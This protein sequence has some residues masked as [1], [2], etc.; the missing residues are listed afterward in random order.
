MSD[1]RTS[2]I[3]NMTGNMGNQSRKFGSDIHNMGQRGTKAI[4]MMNRGLHGL[5]RGL[6]ALGN[7]YTAFITGAGAAGAVRMV[8]NLEERLTKLGVSSSRSAEDVEKLK[9]EIF[10]IARQK[11]LRVDPDQL[12]SAVEEIVE[13]T[14]DLEY[15]KTNLKNFAAAI[16]A[17]SAE[18]SS[19]GGIASEFQKMGLINPKDVLE[20]LDLLIKQGKEGAFTLAE[21]AELAPRIFPAYTAR[22]RTGMAAV[23]EVGAALQIIMKGTGK[24]EM[25]VTAFESVLRVLADNSKLKKLQK[26]GINVFDNEKMKQGLEVIRPINEIVADIVRKT[27][28]RGTLLSEVLGDAEAARAFSVASTEYMKKGTLNEIDRYYK[29]QA[30][31]KTILADAATNA[32]T[33]NSA[34][35]YLNTSFQV[36][37][38]QELTEPIKAVAGYLNSLEPGTVDLWMKAAKW[39]GIIGVGAIFAR[40][41]MRFL[42]GASGK[43]TAGI[44]GMGDGVVPVYVTNMGGLDGQGGAVKTAGMSAMMMGGVATG[45]LALEAAVAYAV[46]KGIEAGGRKVG[47]NQIKS[48]SD[49]E[50]TDL[51]VGRNRALIDPSGPSAKMIMAE[52]EKRSPKPKWMKSI[53]KE[54]LEAARGE[55]KIKIESA[56]QVSVT[57]M[58]SKNMD[59]TVDTGRIMKGF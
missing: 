55:V 11:D 25:A 7:R 34:M 28:G 9:K 2:I 38:D 49:K 54:Q 50:L 27:K 4:S 59:L 39:I 3:L 8:G 57:G 29:I 37:A 12:F 23:R 36:F 26:A 41:A 58:K 6:D 24:A 51:L 48:F 52:I 46:V 13:R 15:A 32:K 44:Q 31:G 40:K 10:D 5:G 42:P 43:G 19:I 47:E 30:D 56:A 16:K 1:L 22:G 21:M 53:T 35:T 18:G 14:G 17:A 20:G 45:V 33:F